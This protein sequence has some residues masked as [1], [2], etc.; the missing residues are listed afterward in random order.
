MVDNVRDIENFICDENDNLQS[1][2]TKLEIS[3]KGALVV[4]SDKSVI[5][6]ITDGDVRRFF[7]ANSLAEESNAG[8]LCNREF[9]YAKH[10]DPYEKRVSKL[11]EKIKFIP[12]LGDD[13]NLLWIEFR[14][15]VNLS[16][17]KEIVHAR[18]PARMTF[19]GGGSDKLDFFQHSRGLCINAAI[20]KYAFCTICKPDS[21]CFVQIVSTDYHCEWKFDS[22][23]ELTAT[24][25]PRLLIYKTVLSFLNYRQPIKIITHCDFPIGSGLGGSSSLTVAMLHAFN[26]LEG[27][28]VSKI[29]LAQ[30][31]YKL[32]RIAMQIKGGWQDQYVAAVGGINAIYFTKDRHDVHNLKLDSRI[33]LKL[34]ASLYLCFTGSTHDSSKIHSG[35]D[36]SEHDRV[37][38]MKE[39]VRLASEMVSAL[40][41]GDLDNFDD[42]IN[43]NW[44]LKKQ[45]S[46]QISSADL[47]DQI[48]GLRKAGATSV[49]ILG[50]GGGGYFLARVPAT[51]NNEFKLFCN[52]NGLFPERLTFDYDGVVSWT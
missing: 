26:D 40:T 28:A 12:I 38:K 8:R 9:V 5:G 21:G 13:G 18:A 29:R 20:K 37:K 11:S 33:L 45:Y 34:E 19:G 25:D 6:I 4:L 42:N 41:N 36:L 32:E 44:E 17:R 49:K 24:S 52:E 50:A 35:I 3:S 48:L 1:V 16:S 15:E 7:L 39:T 30:D 43:E 22:L 27:H 23:D 14:D 10:T 46:E 2:L 31:A 47:D 51:N